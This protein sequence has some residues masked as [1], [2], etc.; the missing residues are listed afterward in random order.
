MFP[1]STN[2]IKF[3]SS[4]SQQNSAF[5]GNGTAFDNEFD[6]VIGNRT[7]GLNHISFKALPVKRL[8]TIIFFQKINLLDQKKLT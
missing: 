8:R 7:H 2:D 3:F 1:F 6:F 4:E 5:R